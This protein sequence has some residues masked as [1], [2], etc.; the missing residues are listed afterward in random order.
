MD[1]EYKYD[2]FSPLDAQAFMD[3]HKLIQRDYA[4]N[5]SHE[6]MRMLHWQTMC[7]CMCLRFKDCHHLFEAMFATA[8]CEE[9]F[10][11]TGQPQFFYSDLRETM[12]NLSSTLF[13]LMDDFH[14]SYKQN[15]E[16]ITDPEYDPFEVAFNTMKD[17]F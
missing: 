12:V 13:T 8:T 16:K 4:L 5:L 7:L 3:K 9:K 6:E 15:P 14:K 11:R 17:L 10:S 2:K 1:S